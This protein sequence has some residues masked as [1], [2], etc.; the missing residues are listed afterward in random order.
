M[1]DTT[2]EPGGIILYGIKAEIEQ[3][4]NPIPFPLLISLVE[5]RCHVINWPQID[6]HNG[7]GVID[8]GVSF[9]WIGK[10]I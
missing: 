2:P 1:H 9:K 3:E 7:A 6:C 8:V 4:A 5:T 10:A